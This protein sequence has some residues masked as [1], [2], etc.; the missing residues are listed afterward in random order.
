MIRAELKSAA[1]AQIKGNIGMLFLCY[2]IVFAISLAVG[3]VPVIGAIISVIITPPLS[4][5]L[6]LV[7]LGLTEGKKAEV[8]TLFQG[9]QYFGK[10]ILLML[11][12]AIFT[13]L[14]TLL[15]WIPGIIKGLSY[16]MAYYVMAD[17]PQMTAREALNESKAIMHG[18]KWDLFVLYLSFIPWILLVC[19]TFGIAAIYVVPYQST[20]IANFYQNIKRQSETIASENMI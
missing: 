9:F 2:L 12:I 4:V 16:S 1:K 19:V 11:L 3:F 7:Y 20:T 13:F 10:S 15:L 17:N 5:G 14:W 8:G 6:C 18:H